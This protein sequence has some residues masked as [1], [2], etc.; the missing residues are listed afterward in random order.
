[1]AERI[2]EE[3]LSQVLE[4]KSF[5]EENAAPCGAKRK[6]DKKGNVP[7]K[8]HKAVEAPGVEVSAQQS[9]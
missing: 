1:M 2:G 8:K 9:W 7:R 5:K 3:G 6:V 4:D